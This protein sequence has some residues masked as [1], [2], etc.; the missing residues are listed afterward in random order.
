MAWTRLGISLGIW[1]GRLECPT[2]TLLSVS[3]QTYGE[4]S[5]YFDYEPDLDTNIQ[6]LGSAGLNRLYLASK[7][8]SYE[9]CSWYALIHQSGLEREYGALKANSDYNLLLGVL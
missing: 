7:S 3:M 1:K 8:F 9:Y 2:Y 6:S 5:V 4:S